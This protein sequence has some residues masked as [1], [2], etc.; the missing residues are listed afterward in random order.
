MIGFPCNQFLGQE[1]GSDDEIQACTRERHSVRF[2][3]LAKTDVNGG[4]VDQVFAFIKSELPGFLGTTSVKW[5]F[6]KF[7][8][9]RDGYGF[10]RYSPQ[11]SPEACCADIEFLLDQP[12]D[13]PADAA[14]VAASE[15]SSNIVAES[16]KTM[17]EAEAEAEAKL[18]DLVL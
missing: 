4:A 7:L 18:A 6:T 1:P 2:P 9:G 10:R 5:N 11:V 3:I 13:G 14:G 12:Y 8:I 16:S 15:N 17:A